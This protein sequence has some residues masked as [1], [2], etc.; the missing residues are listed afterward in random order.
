MSVSSAMQFLTLLR[1]AKLTGG[2]AQYDIHRFTH[3][4]NQDGMQAHF[5]A[6]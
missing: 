5:V 3:H 1:K 6:S 2:V 4:S